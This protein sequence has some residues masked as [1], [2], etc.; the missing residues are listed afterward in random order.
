M[1]CSRCRNRAEVR[2]RHIRGMCRN[3]FSRLVIKRVKKSILPGELIK[4]NDKIL[5]L[6]RLCLYF[7]ERIISFPVRII[8]KPRSF[9]KIKNFDK[10][11]FKNNVLKRFAK[12]KKINKIIIPWT[13]DQEAEGFMEHLFS[14]CSK[15][16]KN[17]AF[18]RLF[19]KVLE[20]EL[21][22]FAKYKKLPFKKTAKSNVGMFLNNLEKKY[23]G[24]LFSADKSRHKIEGI[25]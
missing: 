20:K 5:V 25:P 10:D 21:E 18:V 12:D 15:K 19:S 13:L 3:C 1:Q 7:I 2:L 11:I 17:A 23:A 6:D 8:R 14:D 16:R 24:T 9:F 22:I 4:K